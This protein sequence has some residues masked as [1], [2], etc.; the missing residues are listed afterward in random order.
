MLK[1]LSSFIVRC[2]WS[3]YLLHWITAK[4]TLLN[5]WK[6]IWQTCKM[7][8]PW[9][10]FHKTTVVIPLFFCILYHSKCQHFCVDSQIIPAL[11]T[12]L[13]ICW[14]AHYWHTTHTYWTEKIDFCSTVDQKF[15]QI[16]KSS[17]TGWSQRCL[18]MAPNYAI[19]MLEKVSCR[20]NKVNT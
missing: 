13:R 9:V 16:S 10:L 1:L 20:N 19:T 18:F 14:E 8:H 5:T 6:S 7:L 15:S 4:I 11:S 12:Q 3:N 17:G 2:W